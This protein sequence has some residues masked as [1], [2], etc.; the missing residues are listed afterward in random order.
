MSVG[1]L[2]DVK[3]EASADLVRTWRDAQRTGSSRWATHDVFS[4]KP[5]QEFLGP[6]LDQLHLSVRLDITRGV[7][8]KDELKALRLMRDTGAVSQFTIGGSL[9]GDFVVKD[10]SEAWMR[11]DRAGVLTLA[12]V[13]LALEEYQ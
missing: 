8:P 4:R 10:L 3:F 5:V 6:G 2:G 13:T 1:I 9:V 12:D 11:F 7:V